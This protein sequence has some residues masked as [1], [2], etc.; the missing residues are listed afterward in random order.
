M[1]YSRTEGRVT[2]D[3]SMVLTVPA[4]LFY[5]VLLCLHTFTLLPSNKTMYQNNLDFLWMFFC[6]HDSY[7][8]VR[9]CPVQKNNVHITSALGWCKNIRDSLPPQSSFKSLH[10]WITYLCMN[11]NVN[12]SSMIVKWSSVM[13]R[14]LLQISQNMQ[15]MGRIV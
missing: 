9:P 10:G 5:S 14:D 15:N 3:I 6:H 13:S 8:S 12:H 7:V 1:S 2:S 4:M 11:G